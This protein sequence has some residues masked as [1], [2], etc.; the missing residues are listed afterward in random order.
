[1]KKLYSLVLLLTLLSGCSVLERGNYDENKQG[2]V[3]KNGFV[4]SFKTSFEGKIDV[5]IIDQT[6]SFLDAI[7]LANIDLTNLSEDSIISGN[8][9]TTCQ[10]SDVNYLP[11]YIRV[12][13]KTYFYNVSDSGNCSYDQYMFHPLGYT[14][15]DEYDVSE[16][17]PVEEEHITLFREADFYVNPFESLVY[18]EDIQYDEGLVKWEKTVFS[19]VPMSKRQEGNMFNDNQ[20]FFEQVMILEN[21]LLTYQSVNLLVLKPDY[22]AL[23]DN[24]IWSEETIDKLGR[25]N[26]II[27]KVKLEETSEILDL[28]NEAL[29]R[30]GMFN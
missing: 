9:L 5:F 3:Y 15:L 25:D 20:E 14:D 29:S 28:I 12:N 11:K 19:P 17:S 30:L 24:N 16:T 27:K 13:D 18:I 8:D 10:I 23:V 22:D 21:Y 4:A 2:Y 7:S 1:M 6:N 26:D